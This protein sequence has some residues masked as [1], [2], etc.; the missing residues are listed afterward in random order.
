M[1]DSWND[2]CRYWVEKKGEFDSSH[3]NGVRTIDLKVKNTTMTVVH[4]DLGYRTLPIPA[5][6]VVSLKDAKL[7]SNERY[8][9][10]RFTPV[11]ELLVDYSEKNRRVAWLDVKM[12]RWK[13]YFENDENLKLF[14]STITFIDPISEE[15]PTLAVKYIEDP[16]FGRFS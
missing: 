14:L 2:V 7:S 1:A 9:Y 15:K 4:T 12:H 16:D 11:K 5:G 3:V 10:G 6:V 8:I 13:R